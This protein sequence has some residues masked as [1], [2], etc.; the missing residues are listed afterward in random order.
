MP[1]KVVICIKIKYKFQLRAFEPVICDHCLISL[2]VAVNFEFLKYR[3]KSVS[4][5]FHYEAK[6][7]GRFSQ[8]IVKFD[9]L[10]RK[11]TLFQSLIQK[12]Q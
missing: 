4:C 3:K 2:F 12:W 8:L 5:F 7:C 1:H 6:K 10:N 9:K 11:F